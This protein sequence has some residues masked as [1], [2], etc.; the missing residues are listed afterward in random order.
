MQMKRMSYF[1]TKDICS[2]AYGTGSDNMT[3]I[4]QQDKL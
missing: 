2:E 4:L 1:D 3:Y